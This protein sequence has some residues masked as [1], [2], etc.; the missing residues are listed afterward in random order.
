MVGERAGILSCSWAGRSA[1]AAYDLRDPR[2]PSLVFGKINLL[3][4]AVAC[5]W[6]AA[7]L[8]YAPRDAGVRVEAAAGPLQLLHNMRRARLGTLRFPVI[9]IQPYLYMYKYL[10]DKGSICIEQTKREQIE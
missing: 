8:L 3:A 10:L 7:R 9:L 2:P 5:C 4:D 1:A 6:L